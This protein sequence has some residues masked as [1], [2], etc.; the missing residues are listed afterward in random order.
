MAIQIGETF[1][2]GVQEPKEIH[3]LP[4]GKVRLRMRSDSLATA[5]VRTPTNIRGY[6][7]RDKGDHWE[8]AFE[9]SRNETR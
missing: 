1:V 4:A 7:L 3:G 8:A 6:V 5:F 2:F 9:L